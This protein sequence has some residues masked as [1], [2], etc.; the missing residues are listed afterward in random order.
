MS[1]QNQSAP[2]SQ[3][4]R[5]A[6]IDKW[7]PK[8][9]LG[10]LVQNG[11]IKSMAQVFE[12]NMRVKEIEIVQKLIP[13]LQEIL[14]SMKS[15]QRM[16]RSGQR[17]SHKAVV[18][19]GD[20]NGHIGIGH[21]SAKEAPDAIRAAARMA[22]LNIRPIRLG[23]FGKAFG[24]PHTVRVKS[25]GKS[26]S[27]KLRILPAAKG[28]GIKAGPTAKKILELAG[29]KDCYARSKGQTCTKENTAKALIEALEGS[30]NYLLE[31][32]WNI[33]TTATIVDALN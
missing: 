13:E 22:R 8:T 23:Y 14:V 24:E 16:T 7:R 31:D 9:N 26:G 29:I 18:I 5:P 30:S 17:N 27:V 19:V 25:S 12:S 1:T 11:K 28:T 10:R 4:P 33:K 2:N 3:Q 20:R 21:K 32:D 15:V 6:F